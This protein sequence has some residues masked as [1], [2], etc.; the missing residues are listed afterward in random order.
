M[1]RPNKRAGGD[2]GTALQFAFRGPRSRRASARALSLSMKIS[3]AIAVFGVLAALAVVAALPSDSVQVLGDLPRAEA[4]DINRTV[5]QEIRP[6]ILPD[7]SPQSLRSA[8]SLLLGRLPGHHPK[9]LVIERRSAGFVAVIGRKP[10]DV[11]GTNI[12][13]GFFKETNGWRLAQSHEW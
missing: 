2:G 3:I 10:A 7:L 8:P 13:W 5:Q 1:S 6:R 4:A 9:V 12:L 11:L